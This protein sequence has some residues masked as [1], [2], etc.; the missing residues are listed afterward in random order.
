P[1][2][3]GAAAPRGTCRARSCRVA[4]AVDGGRPPGRVLQGDRRG[5]HTYSSMSRAVILTYHAIE[6]GPQPLCIGP[7]L[8][9]R[10]LEVIDSSGAHLL[11]VAALAAALR[12]G[13]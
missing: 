7:E 12:A 8:F 10:H 3:T 9:A 6:D 5:A 11:T 2:P 13:E 1:H 4:R